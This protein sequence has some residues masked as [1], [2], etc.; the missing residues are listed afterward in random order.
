MNNTFH[1]VRADDQRSRMRRDRLLPFAEVV[2]GPNIAQFALNGGRR[3]SSTASNIWIG[4][5][6]MMVEIACL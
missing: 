1:H 5:A 3:A 4:A 2:L 6:G